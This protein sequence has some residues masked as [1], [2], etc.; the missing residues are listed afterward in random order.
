MISAFLAGAA[1]VEVTHSGPMVAAAGFLLAPSLDLCDHQ[2]LWPFEEGSSPL[3]A[4]DSAGASDAE[5]AFGKSELVP[6]DAESL[7]PAGSAWPF[8]LQLEEDPGLVAEQSEVELEVLLGHLLCPGTQHQGVEF[9][10]WCRAAWYW[11]V[12]VGVARQA[13]G[14]AEVVGSVVL[15]AAGPLELLVWLVS[16]KAILAADLP[17]P[18]SACSPSSFGASGPAA[19]GAEVA[20]GEACV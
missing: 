7:L 8:L 17:R 16:V 1:V 13:V 9:S 11:E 18:S 2:A 10:A 19:D 12:Q 4:S 3:V 20:V 6:S 14:V 5:L 15:A